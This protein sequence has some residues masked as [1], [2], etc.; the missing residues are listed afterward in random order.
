MMHTSPLAYTDL[1]QSMFRFMNIFVYQSESKVWTMFHDFFLF[2]IKVI[3]LYFGF[4]LQFFS[5]FTFKSVVEL[6]TIL[7]V[8]TVWFNISVKNTIFTV[9]KREIIDLWHQLND[10]EFTAKTINEQRYVFVDLPTRCQS[11][12][13]N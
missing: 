1:H 10:D 9:R 11:N 5:L 2:A 3:F 13:F 6:S 12:S 8:G 4:V 7:F